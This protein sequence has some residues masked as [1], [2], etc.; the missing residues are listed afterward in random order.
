[1]KIIKIECNKLDL[2]IWMPWS[3]ANNKL[4][5]TKMKTRYNEALETLNILKFSILKKYKSQYSKKKKS[6]NPLVPSTHKSAQIAQNFVGKI[7]RDRQK[8]FLWA[9]RLWVGRRKEPI[10]GYLPKNYKKNSG[11]KG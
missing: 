11:S 8:N 5:L 4:I 1:M 2:I 6:I 10:L 3:M 7:R 9:S